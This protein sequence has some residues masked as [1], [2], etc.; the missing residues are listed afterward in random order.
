MTRHNDKFSSTGD[1]IGR[2]DLGAFGS[3]VIA[4]DGFDDYD[5]NVI[6]EDNDG[7]E[8]TVAGRFR[9]EREDT[10]EGDVFADLID[11]TDAGT[12]NMPADPSDALRF[13]AGPFVCDGCNRTWPG[14]QNQTPDADT[15]VCPECDAAEGS[16]VHQ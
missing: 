10:N 11:A 12:D 7:L 6:I 3:L 4:D 8:H 2:I 1:E 14:K 5:V 15:D 9:A 13:T 16:G